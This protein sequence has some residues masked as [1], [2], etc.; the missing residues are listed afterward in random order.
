MCNTHDLHTIYMVVGFLFD[1]FVSWDFVFKMTEFQMI[2]SSKVNLGAT[3]VDAP[4]AILL[5]NKKVSL[6]Y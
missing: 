2:A 4:V 1:L 5:S 3:G 6:C